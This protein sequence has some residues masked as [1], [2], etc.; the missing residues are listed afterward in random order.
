VEKILGKGEQ[1][2]GDGS[3][4]AGQFGVAMEPAGGNKGVEIYVWESGNKKITVFF[5][6]GKV[7]NKASTGL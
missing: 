4:M 7:A 1:E 6:Q 5:R 3:N 2:T